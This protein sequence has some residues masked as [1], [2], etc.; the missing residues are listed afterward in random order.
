MWR[1]LNFFQHQVYLHAPSPRVECP[2]CGIRQARLPW[3]RPRSGF[4]LFFE[5]LALAMM[6]EMRVKAV[7]RIVG[8]HDTRLWPI[9]RHYMGEARA[10]ADHSGVRAVGVDEKASRR[11]HSYVTFFADLDQRRRLYATEGRKWGVLG[12]FQADLDAHGG[13]ADGIEELCMDMSPADIK[14]ARESFPDAEITFDRFHVVKL[15]N[16]AVEK[17]RRTEKKERPELKRRRSL[18]NPDGLSP[19]QR[20]RLDELLDPSRDRACHGPGI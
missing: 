10:A 12:Q 13:S 9:A 17:V 11:G 8:E 5:A 3:A 19:A 4:A 7:A 20:Q 2:E 15:L 6:S 1:H 18:W 14:G 16:E